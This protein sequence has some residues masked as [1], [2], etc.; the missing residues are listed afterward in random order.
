MPTQSPPEKI[1]V[2]I[3]DESEATG[4]VK[5]L[6]DQTL[7]EMNLPFVPDI[8]LIFSSRPEFLN[9]AVQGVTTLFTKSKLPPEVRELIITWTSKLNDCG[10]CVGAHSFFLRLFG[11]S[12]ELLAAAQ[13]AATVEDLPI[14]ARTME[15]LRLTTKVAQAAY[16]VTDDDWQRSCDAG[17]TREQV[18]DAV[19]AAS[20]YSFIVRFVSS[21]GLGPDAFAAMFVGAE[22]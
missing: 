20:F 11:G 14:D 3:V 12:E 10:Y 2:P 15:L 13:N 8:V 17:W 6:Y 7:A 16:K 18:M 22:S 5:E 4:R 9:V 21:S 19:F 1:R